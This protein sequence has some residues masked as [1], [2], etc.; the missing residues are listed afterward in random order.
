MNASA[1]E[2]S[3][4][5]STRRILT[6]PNVLSLLRLG[7]V[8]VFVWLFVTGRELAAAIIYVAG[9]WS[10]FFDGYIARR[11][12]SVSEFGKLLDPL[13]DRIFI[14]ALAVALLARD[15]LPWSL[16][17]V[18]VVRD[19]LVLGFFPVLERRGIERI[20]VNFVGKAAT[21]CL[22]FGLAW[23]AA[24]FVWEPLGRTVGLVV[25]SV[26]ALLYWVAGGLYAREA[27]AK[28]RAQGRRRAA[29]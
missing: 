26:G 7:T 17:A 5:A 16:V 28:L 25:A 20:E 12:N 21:A 3:S 24:S 23:I 11:T 9:A 27:I 2:P 1:S 19:L 10:D 4:E 22:L 8:P 13:A 14:A 29:K 6:I 18:V 15:A